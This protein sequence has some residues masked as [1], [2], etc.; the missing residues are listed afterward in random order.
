MATTATERISSVDAGGSPWESDS[1]STWPDGDLALVG[2]LSAEAEGPATPPWPTD[3]ALSGNGQTWVNEATDTVTNGSDESVRLNLWSVELSSPSTGVLTASGTGTPDA[4]AVFFKGMSVSEWGTGIV[5]VATNSGT[6]T[7]ASVTLSAFA[8][9]TN[10]LVVMWVAYVQ[11]FGS[12]SINI[13]S[14][15]LTELGA[16]IDGGFDVSIAQFWSTGEDTTPDV[17]LSGSTSW[18]A[19]AA[20]IDSDAGGGGG[21]GTVPKKMAGHG[22][23]AGRGGFAGIGGGF[24]AFE[25]VGSLFQPSRKIH[26]PR[27]IVPV[28]I[29]LQGA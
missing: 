18:V 29:Q 12:K 11:G 6:G 28:G 4:A 19:I 1:I 24:A 17:Q 25:K 15:S 10:N 8:D 9:A 2:V 13:S 3:Q 20:E 23:H 26:R 7:A 27:L 22:G 5:Q 16:D 14:S 21:G